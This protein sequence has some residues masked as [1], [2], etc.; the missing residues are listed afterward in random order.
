MDQGGGKAD[1]MR[2]AFLGGWIPLTYS[3]YKQS[4]SER[5][6][7]NGEF[8]GA[9]GVGLSMEKAG[10]CG[11]VQSPRGWRKMATELQGRTDHDWSAESRD[12]SGATPFPTLTERMRRNVLLIKPCPQRTPPTPLQQWFT[13]CLSGSLYILVNETTLAGSGR[14]LFTAFTWYSQSDCLISSFLSPTAS[15]SDHQRIRRWGQHRLFVLVQKLG[16]NR[17]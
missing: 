10:M 2:M 17:M 12:K 9:A 13:L 14:L 16:Q 5:E 15:L 6:F 8:W 3:D 4:I 11:R 1:N 7:M